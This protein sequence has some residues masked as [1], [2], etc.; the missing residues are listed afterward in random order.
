MP[1]CMCCILTSVLL[2]TPEAVGFF[3]E[4]Q[5]VDVRAQ[6]PHVPHPPRHHHLLLDDVGLRKVSPSLWRRH[7]N[8][9]VT[10]TICG[11]GTDCSSQSSHPG[12][13]SLAMA[14]ASASPW[15]WRAAPTGSSGASPWSCS[16]RWCSICPKR[17]RSKLWGPGMDCSLF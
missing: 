10:R 8:G 5:P 7:T 14:T 13:C 6:L 1:E 15:R 16:A 17:C 9:W 4:A 3:A 12:Q 11:M 2:A